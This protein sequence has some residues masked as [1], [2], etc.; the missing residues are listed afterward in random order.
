MARDLMPK[1]G[2]VMPHIVVTRDAAV[3]G[4][5]T[6]DGK[7]GTI[8]LSTTYAKITDVYKKTE[9]YSQTEVN[10]LIDPI[11]QRALFKDDPYINNNVALRSGGANGITSIDLIK[12][13][14]DNSIHIGDLAAGVQ[15]IHLYSEGKIDVAYKDANGDDA[16]AS[17]YSQRYRPATGEL[18]FAVVGTYI[19]DAKGRTTGVNKNGNNSDIKVLNALTSVTTNPVVFEK[20]PTVPDP[21]SPYDAVT[22]RYVDNQAGGGTGATL[23]GVMNF[24]VGKPLIHATRA[25]I[26]AYELPL[27]GQLV[28][29]TTYPDLWAWAQATTPLTDAAWVAD[30]TK[31]GSYST[32]DGS[33]TFRLPDWNGVQKNGVNGFTGADSIPGVFFR[34]GNG[35]ADMIMSLSAAPEIAG[36]LATD[37]NGQA[38]LPAGLP[39][40]S[41]V[42]INSVGNSFKPNAGTFST[43][44]GNGA[45]D[46]K[47]SYSSAVYGRNSSSEVVPNKVSGVWVVRASGG[48]TA[49]NTSWSVFNGDA[50]APVVGAPVK[51]GE[52]RSEYQIGGSMHLRSSI[53]AN[54]LY[55][56]SGGATWRVDDSLGNSKEIKFG[57]DGKVT[58][59]LTLSVEPA[60]DVNEVGVSV[61]R[62]AIGGTTRFGGAMFMGFNRTTAG[63]DFYPQV[64]Q[65]SSVHVFERLFNTAGAISATFAKHSG[66]D[67]TAYNGNFVSGSDRRIKDNITV[68]ENP[69][70][71]MKKIRGYSWNLKSNGEYGIGFVAQEV[72]QAF[73]LAV[74][75]GNYT[76]E[77]PD[78]SKVKNV[79][80]LNAG[81]VAAALHHEAILVLMKENEN[82]KSELSD[83][84]A[85]VQALIN[86]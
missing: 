56:Q 28:S 2:I 31:R 30:P 71:L 69:L 16:V 39:A 79:K 21:V 40:G 34:G 55:S 77:L 37:L 15:G 64:D 43:V 72:E 83:L 14:T 1:S 38:W 25:F 24:G 7:A 27:D 45:W 59:P 74:K 46:F 61:R 48:F 57:L 19:T 29:R 32:G 35:G 86:K 12:A 82:L 60:N 70:E 23:N 68:V 54:G 63:Y 49:A 18:P 42:P 26:P 53:Y 11:V 76:Q 41:F 51:G 67:Y 84:K 9:T 85:T 13:A 44:Q 52:V 8:D 73:P 81:N 58:I 80:T 6:V 22:K 75:S 10:D 4:V 5:S 62:D 50:S 36:Q 47:A 65:D 20:S 3:V 78:G 66:G 33:T 17:L